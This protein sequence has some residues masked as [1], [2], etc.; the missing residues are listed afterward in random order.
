MAIL[1]LN[2]RYLGKIIRN[3]KKLEKTYVR[4]ETID[5]L[6]F[7]YYDVHT[8]KEVQIVSDFG[9]APGHT[10]VQNIISAKEKP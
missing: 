8:S 9:H 7:R 10:S 5:I 2:T 6:R 1:I 3:L 4:F